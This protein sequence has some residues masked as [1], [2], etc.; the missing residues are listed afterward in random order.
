MALLRTTGTDSD[1]Q[2]VTTE[3]GSQLHH[4][5]GRYVRTAVNMSSTDD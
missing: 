5:D 1:C 3:K 4:G 2:T